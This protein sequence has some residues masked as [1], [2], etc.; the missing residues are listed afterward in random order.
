MANGVNFPLLCLVSFTD[1][2]SVTRDAGSFMAMLP[3]EF[4]EGFAEI[5]VE[6]PAEQCALYSFIHMVTLVPGTGHL[7][8][9]IF[10]Q[11]G[12]V[13]GLGGHG[14]QSHFCLVVR[15]RQA[16]PLL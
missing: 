7:A 12:P 8:A 3:G 4:P 9:N 15:L 16:P 13:R 5:M 14:S 10:P 2:T 6:G 1:F 11:P